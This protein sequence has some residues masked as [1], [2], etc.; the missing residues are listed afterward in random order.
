[1][2]KILII[3]W[4]ENC[5]KCNHYEVF[6]KTKGNQELLYEGDT[7]KCG[8]CDHIGEIETDGINA[9]VNWDES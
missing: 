1:M 9:W 8:A 5:N 7:V 2:N 4:L 3:T 6:V